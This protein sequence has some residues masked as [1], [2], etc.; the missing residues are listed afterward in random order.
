M[1]DEV[2]GEQVGGLVAHHGGRVE[3]A[4]VVGDG[5]AG[6]VLAE[7]AVARLSVGDDGDVGVIALVAGPA[8][9]DVQKAKGLG[10]AHGGFLNIGLSSRHSSRHTP[11]A[12]AGGGRHTEC[13]CYCA[14]SSPWMMTSGVTSSRGNRAGQ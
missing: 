10:R 11:C 8:V 9:G 14:P 6:E 5:L 7:P 3:L 4:K 2:Q 13:A 12:V 1:Q